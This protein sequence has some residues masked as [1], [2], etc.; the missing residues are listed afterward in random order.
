MENYK[1]SQHISI[2]PAGDEEYEDIPAIYQQ[3]Y[4]VLYNKV[5]DKEYLVNSTIKYF[6][7]K[8]ST[9]KALAQVIFEI[10][11]EV[12]GERAEIEETCSSFFH[13][14][15]KRRILVPE[16][17]DESFGLREPFY[18]VRDVIGTYTIIELLANK[19]Y[20]DVYSV[21][22]NSDGS[23]CVLK[24]LNKEKTKDDAIF[25]Q[26]CIELE[27]EYLLLKE[28]D[29]IPM[30]CKAYGFIRDNN[31]NVYI[32]LEFINGKPL[33]DFVDET[34][35][36]TNSDLLHIIESI[37]NAFSLLHQSN[38]IHG[39][40]HSSNILVLPGKDIKI[41]DLGLSRTVEIDRDEILPFGGVNYYMPPERINTTSVKKYSKEPD[42]Y[43]DVYQV[44][45]LIYLV[46]YNDLPFD[47][48]L[49]EDLSK[50]IKESKVVYPETSYLKAEVPGWIIDIME[51]CLEK[52]PSNR[53]IHAGAILEDFK[54]HAFAEKE[55]A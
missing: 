47:G 53:Y 52:N 13:Y 49:W 4:F 10:E 29:H 36:L 1:V 2:S 45:L 22:N 43:S 6:I 27:R 33:F 7:D 55:I 51:K 31:Q 54:K 37:L 11:K 30:M 8:F 39:D 42:L 28:V 50:N 23:T 48:F 21:V 41:I 38:V 9:P 16:E 14:L 34:E 20:M 5:R 26:E 35:G 15:C 18:A 32:I 17:Q 3:D 44:G 24:L 46:L 12:K 19:R 25:Q 40:I